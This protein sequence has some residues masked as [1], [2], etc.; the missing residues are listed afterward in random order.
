MRYMSTQEAAGTNKGR[1]NVKAIAATAIIIVICA[2]VVVWYFQVNP[3]VSQ[4]RQP[5]PGE[6]ASVQRSLEEGRRMDIAS[7]D[8]RTWN[9]GDTGVYRLVV[10]N[11]YST[12]E[13]F[14][15]D[16][17]LEKLGGALDG[18]PVDSLSEK[19]KE[20]FTYPNKFTLGPGGEE[21][22][23]ISM[24]I[25][26]DTLKGSYKFSVLVCEEEGCSLETGGVYDSSSIS[27][28]ANG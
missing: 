7:P 28:N 20:W 13:T 27:L 14:Y 22:I 25:P 3:L 24:V 18:T 5:G 15:L 2:M 4:D 19:T 9:N 11:R 12:E 1:S 23:S 16:I 10:I 26:S 6:T 21:A 17:A 8:R